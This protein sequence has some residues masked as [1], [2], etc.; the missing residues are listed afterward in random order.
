[1]ESTKTGQTKWRSLIEAKAN[2]VVGIGVTW[3]S[4][5]VILPLFGIEVSHP[6]IVG[7]VVVFTFVSVARQFVLRRLFNWWDHGQKNEDQ[8]GVDEAPASL[9]LSCGKPR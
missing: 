1:M 6:Q 9:C 5:L 4:Y 8:R 2:V 7:L 3:S